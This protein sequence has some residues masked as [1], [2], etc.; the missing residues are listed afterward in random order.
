MSASRRVRPG[1]SGD[2][3]ASS[4]SRESSATRSK[5]PSVDRY[6][7]ISSSSGSIDPVLA[8]AEALVEPPFHRL[9]ALARARASRFRRPGRAP[10]AR[11]GREHVGLPGLRDEQQVGLDDVEVREHDVERRD[12]HRPTWCPDVGPQQGREV[13]DDRLVLRVR[14]RRHE[15]L[16]VDQLVPLPVVGEL[17]EVVVGEPDVGGWWPHGVAPGH[18]VIV[19]GGAKAMPR[20]RPQSPDRAGHYGV[21]GV[22]GTARPR[23]GRSRRLR[24]QLPGRGAAICHTICRGRR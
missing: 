11:A 2:S 21:T 24:R 10:H 18:E 22:A 13:H 7:L 12:E 14:R 17:Q 16:P 20:L 1:N 23:N 5:R 15:V 3:S 9:V 6:T 19:A 4:C 8:D